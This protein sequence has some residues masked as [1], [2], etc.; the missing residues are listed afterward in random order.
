M[1]NNAA[2][3]TEVA[4]AET[5]EDQLDRMLNVNL[6]GVFFGCKHAVLAMR[7]HGSGGA[8]VNVASILALVA[9]P[10]LPAYCATKGGILG[11]TRATAVCYG[12][13][14]IRCNAICPGDID[15]PALARYFESAGDP[16]A[17]RRQIES[18]Y[19]LRRIAQ[20]V[21]IA[22]GV[23]FLAC[24]ESSFMTGQE[25]ILDGGLLADVY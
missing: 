21:E 15:T 19:P 4:L 7:G 22:R 24:E 18:E 14:G 17:R 6:K 20:P 25:L 5:T 10:M 3:Q 16:V 8:I 23:V 9:D 11:L 12:V 13:D 1:V 2:V